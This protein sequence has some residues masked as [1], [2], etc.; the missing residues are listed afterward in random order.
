[1][2]KHAVYWAAMAACAAMAQ[3][4]YA[5]TEWAQYQGNAQH[6]GYANV[7]L[8]NDFSLAWAKNFSG[9]INPVAAADGS[10]FVTTT[11]YFAGQYL[12]ALDA[13][14]GQERWSKNFGSIYSV[15]PPSYANGTVY[16]QTGN[17]GGDSYFRGYNSAS[18]DLVVK[19][20]FSAQWERYQ[21]PTLLNGNAYVNGGYYGG[22]Y[23]FNLASGN[24]RWFT[25]LEQYDGWTPAV[26]DKY[27]VTYTGGNLR[28]LDPNT[29]AVTQT[30][31]D[32]NFSWSG[33]TAGPAP[34]LVGDHAFETAAGHLSSF[35]LLTGGIDWS[36]SGVTGQ[37]AT[38]GHEIFAIR[39][40]TLSSLDLLTGATNWM[41]EDPGNSSF[42][43]EVLATQ[44][45]V[46]VSGSSQSYV[47]D[48]VTH[49]VVKT[50]GDTGRIALGND[51]M[52]I[53][54]ASGLVAYNV[55][56]VPEP[57][58]LMLMALGLGGLALARRKKT[59]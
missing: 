23:S 29:G 45:Y 41:W 47:I 14:T 5:A 32:P 3:T 34:V 31:S 48:R 49:K 57:A 38:D 13:A 7:T 12:Y 19:T 4:A 46:F 24:Q 33:W 15:N 36:V 20:P 26:S 35:N 44:N 56:T 59:A 55:T 16:L 11:G 40:G 6:T 22:A 25:G 1:M 2:F 42:S 50:F 30:I 27:V 9:G 52:Y 58:S 18:G 10:V 53:A 37:I 17:H 39:N 51:M 8:S 54:T 43:G 21:A 28:V